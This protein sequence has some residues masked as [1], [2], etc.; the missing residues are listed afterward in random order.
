MTTQ[1]SNVQSNSKINL[2][3]IFIIQFHSSFALEITFLTRY[4]PQIKINSF[5][6]YPIFLQKLFSPLT[7]FINHS[8]FL[9]VG[10][11][12]RHVK[13]EDGVRMIARDPARIRVH[14]GRLRRASG[15][16]SV[17][18]LSFVYQSPKGEHV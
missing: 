9:F 3:P 7:K 2:P 13:L 15:I 14:D 11:K 8:R 17:Y 10:G 12:W 5:K 6:S 1:K 18:N 16:R 4:S